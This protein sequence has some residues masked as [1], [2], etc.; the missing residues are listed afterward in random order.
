M[1]SMKGK[2]RYD[3]MSKLLRTSSRSQG[4]SALRAMTEASTS[5]Y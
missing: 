5:G 1:E 4:M 2:V 3:M